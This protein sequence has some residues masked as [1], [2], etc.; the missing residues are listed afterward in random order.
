VNKA[1]G[2]GAPTPDHEFLALNSRLTELQGAVALA[3]LDKLEAGV[4]QR[5]AMAELLTSRLEGIPGL[6]CPMP[7]LDDVHTYWKYAVR[8]DPGVIDGGPVGLAATLKDDDIASAPRYIQKPAFACRVIAEQRTFGA[9]RFPFTL[10]RPEAVDYSREL[11][12]G[13]YRTLDTVLVLPI[14]ERYEPEHVGHVA[15]S[16]EKAVRG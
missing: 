15:D 1:W 7:R 5:V 16:I 14:N 8:V 13:T 11:F 3:Q 4:R 12:P 6:S 10:A 2:Y 9:S